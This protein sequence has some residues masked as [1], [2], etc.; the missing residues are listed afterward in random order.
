MC[1]TT[2]SNSIAGGDTPPD[3]R[4][5]SARRGGSSPVEN[6]VAC[7]STPPD[8]ARLAAFARYLR[9]VDSADW[10]AGLKATR[11]LRALG[12]SVVLCTPK[13]A[14]GGGR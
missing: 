9:A 7:G 10:P 3:D 5:S 2:R 8:D 12:L 13:G 1:Q 4:S 6:L 14:T 11:E